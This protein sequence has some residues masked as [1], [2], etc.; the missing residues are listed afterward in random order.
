MGRFATYLVLGTV[1]VTA[2]VFVGAY[3]G[4]VFYALKGSGISSLETSAIQGLPRELLARWVGGLVTR[5]PFDAMA[6]TSLIVPALMATLVGTGKGVSGKRSIVALV[7]LAAALLCAIYSSNLS[8]E[9][10]ANSESYWGAVSLADAGAA[11]SAKR[12]LDATHGRAQSVYVAMTA[13]AV[14]GTAVGAVALA[15]RI[16]RAS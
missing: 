16:G 11:G 4:W 6:T 12:V 7:I 2:L 8:A 10:V 13:L 9:I 1:W 5:M 15:R 3:A 14:L